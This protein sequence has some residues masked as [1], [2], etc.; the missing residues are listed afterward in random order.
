MKLEDLRNKKAAYERLKASADFAIFVRDLQAVVDSIQMN[1][2]TK[3][4]R[5]ANEVYNQE[6]EKG[7]L[8]GLLILTQHVESEIHE[9][10]DQI[11]YAIT[12]GEKQDEH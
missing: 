11:N 8:V 2:L 5:D 6:F 7:K 10:E 4:L 1:V 9:L 3:P 12:E